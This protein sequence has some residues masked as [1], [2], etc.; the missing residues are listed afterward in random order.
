M[1]R[2]A[3]LWQQADQ[4]HLDDEIHALLNDK[5]YVPKV[6]FETPRGLKEAS[7]STTTTTDGPWLPEVA[8]HVDEKNGPAQSV[9]PN[10]DIVAPPAV[11]QAGIP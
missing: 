3:K 10:V 9:Q 2:S 5:Q 8:E 7:G 4:K 1:L 6:V 11:A